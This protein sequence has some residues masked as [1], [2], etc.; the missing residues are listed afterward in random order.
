MQFIN[1][2]L[3]IN[4]DNHWANK[5]EPNVIP[6]P[7]RELEWYEN[8]ETRNKLK[9]IFFALG[10]VSAS[11]AA[12]TTFCFTATLLTV[13]ISASL[14]LG[15][16]TLLIGG[17]YLS[18]MKPSELD[19]VYRLQKRQ[20]LFAGSEV[21]S[22]SI[23][24]SAQIGD[25]V[26][27]NEIQT[28]LKHD[29][30][31]MDYSSFIQKHGMRVLR[32]LNSDNLSILR[33]K[34]LTHVSSFMN[35]EDENLDAILNTEEARIFGLTSDELETLRITKEVEK[36]KNS[37]SFLQIAANITLKLAKKVV[38]TPIMNA[39]QC[40]AVCINL[41]SE[42]EFKKSAIFGLGAVTSVTI[43]AADKILQADNPEAYQIGKQM[44]KF[45]KSSNV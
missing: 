5:I 3:N 9:S 34:F 16:I 39:A 14:T 41:A 45:E 38:P 36:V 27:W 20:E 40:T 22:F 30:N 28:V 26:T 11:T 17:V 43:F 1:Y 6:S 35:Q 29:I 33:I 21:P 12:L 2:L 7:K 25:I 19:P 31:R 37:S 32:F 18:R 24:N 8:T 15:A 4:T 42:G 23:L 44:V 10:I 13:V